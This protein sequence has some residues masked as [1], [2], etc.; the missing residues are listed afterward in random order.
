MRI[1]TPPSSVNCLVA[2]GLALARGAETMRVPKP[3]AGTITT[4]FIAGCKYTRVWAAVQIGFA[5]VNFTS[6]T[7]FTLAAF[8]SSSGIVFPSLAQGVGDRTIPSQDRSTTYA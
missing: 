5:L 7:G 2:V 1:G 3:A 4:T 6:L 8:C